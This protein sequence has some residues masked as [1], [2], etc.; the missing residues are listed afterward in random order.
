M[1]AIPGDASQDA[2]SYITPM[3]Y[4]SSSTCGYCRRSGN[5]QSQKRVST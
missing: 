2:F 3:G 4:M 1:Q 5:G